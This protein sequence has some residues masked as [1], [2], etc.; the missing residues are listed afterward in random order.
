MI[1]SLAS[2]AVR[3]GDNDVATRYYDEAIRSF[4]R[5]GDVK[6]E[7]ESR[8]GLGRLLR[9]T[10]DRTKA[11]IQ[12]NTARR[13]A[14]KKKYYY[15]FARALSNLGIVAADKGR[16]DE[17]CE[18]FQKSKEIG[19]NLSNDFLQGVALNNLGVVERNAGE[20]D[21]ALELHRKSR[22][23]MER[24]SGNKDVA[25]DYYNT[26]IVL[27]HMKQFVEARRHFNLA[28][29]NGCRLGDKRIIALSWEGLGRIWAWHPAANAASAAKLFGAASKL[30]KVIKSPLEPNEETDYD[31]AI[32]VVRNLL[33]EKDFKITFDQVWRQNCA[34]ALS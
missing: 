12:L 23:F 11:S 9:E 25:L 31:R 22:R 3:Q 34:R 4:H 29:E 32:L 33:G 10:G 27:W 16:S 15:G 1:S 7:V 19:E 30:R 28:L 21:L 14:S 26:G 13:L 18:F 6:H 5:L 20:F 8:V 24:A 2:I 17:A